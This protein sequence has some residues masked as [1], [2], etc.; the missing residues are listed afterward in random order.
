[1]GIMGRMQGD[2]KAKSPSTKMRP[3]REGVT[4]GANSCSII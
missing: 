2:R 4:L 3:K 1:M